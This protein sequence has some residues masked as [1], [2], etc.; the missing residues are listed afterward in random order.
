MGASTNPRVFT[1]LDDSEAPARSRHR[2]RA[3]TPWRVGGDA[4]LDAAPARLAYNRTGRDHDGPDQAAGNA[5]SDG[6][7]CAFTCR[8][9]ARGNRP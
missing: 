1:D 2:T 4:A 8:R 3:G 5:L 6:V 7:C 9:T